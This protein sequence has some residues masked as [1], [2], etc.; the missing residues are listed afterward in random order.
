MGFEMSQVFWGMSDAKGL[1][2][3][4]FKAA[5]KPEYPEKNLKPFLGWE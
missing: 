5:E 4:I 2:R 1:Y 3:E